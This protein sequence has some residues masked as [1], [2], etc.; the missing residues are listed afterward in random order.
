MSRRR[1][2]TIRTGRAPGSSVSLFPFLAVLISTMGALILLLVVIAR[3]ARLQA[4]QAG[5]AEAP[6]QNAEHEAD[7]ELVAWRIEQLRASRDAAASRV[8][9]ERLK[10]GQIED[11]A[12]QLK[13]RLAQLQTTWNDL[14]SLG[15][16][17]A[18]SDA[19]RAELEVR[20]REI[21]E[22]Q[23]QLAEARAAAA[24]RRTSYAVVPYEGPNGTRRRPIYIECRNDAVVLQP[25]GVILTADDFDGS[26]GPGN[27]LDAALRALREYLL[28]RGRL[29]PTQGEPYP[30]LLVRPDGIGGLCGCSRGIEIV[31]LGFRI[32]VDRRR[33]EARLRA[34]RPGIGRT[35]VAS[36]CRCP[37]EAVGASGRD[38][39]I[40]PWRRAARLPRR[41][42]PGRRRARK[43][44]FSR[45]RPAATTGRVDGSQY[46]QDG[47]KNESRGGDVGPA[48]VRAARGSTG[49]WVTFPSALCPSR[50]RSAS[51]ATPTA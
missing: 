40:R 23:G 49:R 36:D 27:G 32:R 50:G 16:T 48:F 46:R 35:N 7:R 34:G 45:R 5:E 33:L 51:I 11:H 42:A 28:D 21:R 4:A 39:A 37:G 20:R 10:L 25:E 44:Q 24:E 38:A 6:V 43:R 8:A 19:L 13:D 2:A 15:D 9:E 14:H 12:R 3:H 26:L 47:C 22:A 17:A 31:G 1:A 30:L 18:Q 41:P 29:D